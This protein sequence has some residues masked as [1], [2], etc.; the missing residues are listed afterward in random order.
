M[1]SASNNISISAGNDNEQ[2]MK[3]ETTTTTNGELETKTLPEAE[4]PFNLSEVMPK[5]GK[6]AVLENG[7]HG[8]LLKNDEKK[9]EKD[10]LNINF[11]EK[12][13][14]EAFGDN[15][16][17]EN[18]ENVDEERE[19]CDDAVPTSDGND[20]KRVDANQVDVSGYVSNELLPA[21]GIQDKLKTPET[22]IIYEV[23]AEVETS[24]ESSTT[25]SAEKLQTTETTTADRAKTTETT[26]KTKTEGSTD[27]EHIS[28]PEAQSEKSST[29]TNSPLPKTKSAVEPVKTLTE[30]EDST[31][32]N[33][34][35]KLAMGNSTGGVTPPLSQVN[36][37]HSPRNGSPERSHHS[38]GCH[39][40][41]D[42]QSRAEY[43]KIKSEVTGNG[44]KLH[45]YDYHVFTK[46]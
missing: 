26:T 41:P 38:G 21:G 14:G 31:G 20:V 17:V 2:E 5:D 32:S 45:F 11:H 4:N 22:D 8:V 19:K 7:Q 37:R 18:S 40:F 27:L 42:E 28:G 6:S 12:V 36:H 39:K 30:K 13:N 46:K 10:E 3:N 25:E 29:V 23:A 15:L 16:Q 9:D 34:P 24:S 33:T 1:A 35:T 44:F 43:M